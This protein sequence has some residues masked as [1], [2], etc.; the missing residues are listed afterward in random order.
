MLVAV[1]AQDFGTEIAPERLVT[2]EGEELL[3]RTVLAVDQ[4]DLVGR[5]IVGLAEVLENRRRGGFCRQEPGL[6]GRTRQRQHVAGRG[7]PR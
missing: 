4:Q 3:L 6:P 2:R 7:Q 5:D 1:E